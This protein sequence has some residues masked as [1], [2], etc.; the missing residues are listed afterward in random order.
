MT[1][2]NQIKYL[3]EHFDGLEILDE[4]NPLKIRGVISF[5]AK[6]KELEVI[7]DWFEIEIDIPDDYP[8]Y[9][10][11]I[12]EIQG[13]IQ[14]D[15]AHLNDDSSFCLATPLAERQSF[16]QDPT[17]F[18][19]MNN[20]VIPYLYSYCYWLKHNEYPFGDRSHGMLGV[21]E[22]YKDIFNTN[23]IPELLDGLYRIAQHGYR[24]HHPCPCGSG[25]IVRKCHRTVTQDIAKD[26]TR[27]VL[28][29]D[30]HRIQQILREVRKGKI[31]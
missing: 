27:E 8:K 6:Y 15:Y 22:H 9:L 25:L 21:I 18:G 29:K 2:E 30:L 3:C 19:F 16:N 17:L 7:E 20:L 5:K 12:T 26:D 28:S 10:P 14:S 31:N 1:L 23:A 13:K 24:G 4:I 11:K